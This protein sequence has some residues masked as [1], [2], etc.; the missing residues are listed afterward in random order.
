MANITCDHCQQTIDI[1]PGAY[2]IVGIRREA[3][4]YR[5]SWPNVYVH[6]G[7]CLREWWAARNGNGVEVAD[8]PAQAG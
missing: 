5:T 7:G 8:R 1:K 4:G 6:A 2:K 3:V